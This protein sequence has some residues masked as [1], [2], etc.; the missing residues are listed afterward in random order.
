[1]RNRAVGI[2]ILVA[3]TLL[4]SP[5][6]AQ[7]TV[8][9]LALE[10]L[11]V[12]GFPEV[13]VAVTLPAEML[14]GSG[15]PS[16]TVTEN[17]AAAEVIGVEAESEGREPQDVILLIDTSGSM[18]GEP[19]EDAKQAARSFLEKMSPE[20]RVALISFA[21]KPEVISSFTTDRAA[22]EA[23]IG[24]MQ[25]RGETAV[26]D[27]LVSATALAAKTDRSTTIVLLSDGGDTVSIN[28]FDSA[29]AAVRSAGVPVFVVAL[30]SGEWDPEAL[31]VLATAS[32]GRYLATE[33]SGDLVALYGGIAEELTNRYL[34]TY[35][36]AGGNTKDLDVT[37]S[38]TIDG[39]TSEGAVAFA[40]PRYDTPVD[41]DA[42]T[43]E[44]VKPA[45]W[46]S[47]LSVVLVFLA[48]TVFVGALGI[49]LIR[50][51]ARLER[52]DYYD[53]VQRPDGAA[54]DSF[55]SGSAVRARLIEA[56]GEVAGQRGFT[57]LL[58]H[59]LE[60]AG[61]PLRPVEYIYLHL[62][63][64]FGLSVIVAVLSKSVFPAVIV[65]LIAI[66]LP[67]FLLENAIDRR[68]R[69]FEEQLPEILNLLAGSL[70]VGWGMQQA[71]GLVTEQMAAPASTEFRRVLTEARLGLTVEEALEKMSERLDSDEFRLV[72]TA[73]SIQREV[74]GNLAEVLDIVAQT[75]RARAELKR[76][77]RSLTA[78]G[79]LSGII[80]VGLPF[81]ELILLLIVNPGYM[82][83][84]FSHPFGWFLAITGVVLMIIGTFWLRR[85]LT[86]EV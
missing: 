23:A 10:V 65:A 44:V 79:R 14:G 67:I 21:F 40:N 49:M 62:V 27:A 16:F 63:V 6:L 37:V 42:T 84:M 56:V 25:A 8:G 15:E 4:A 30:E 75:M 22:L 74:G 64:V 36:S 24:G 76:H 54:V 73:I 45:A 77:I 39:A 55:S 47:Q 61:L 38:A 69:E 78:E 80:L 59:K 31:K 5:A 82:T 34:L 35:R 60:Q 11:D 9:R 72:V 7:E 13:T 86:V 83:G 50:P 66:F 18:A 71:I 2:G 41:W 17:A 46:R 57:Q 81:V 3:L 32:G 68:R 33:D 29:V 85:A 52:L 53:Q 19:I 43:I 70:R 1:M 28:S 20:D 48:A 12:E 58:H 51:S 26:H